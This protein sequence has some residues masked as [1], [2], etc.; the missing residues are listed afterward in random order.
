MH[1]HHVRRYSR[2][3]LMPV[4]SHISMCV[5]WHMLSEHLQQ[6]GAATTSYVCQTVLSRIV[7]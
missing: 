4:L 1:E 2:Q 5:L 6:L 3:G 7:E